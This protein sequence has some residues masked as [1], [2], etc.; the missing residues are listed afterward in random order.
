MAELLDDLINQVD[1]S[2]KK[3]NA[4][5]EQRKELHE[6]AAGE[7]QKKEDARKFRDKLIK[8]KIKKNAPQKEEK[9]KK[10]KDDKKEQ[11]KKAKDDVKEFQKKAE[12]LRKK[13]DKM[14]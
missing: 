10:L 2:P 11:N 6:L 7:K 3:P 1:K 12:A 13:V 8:D 9:E 5:L 14:S 4:A